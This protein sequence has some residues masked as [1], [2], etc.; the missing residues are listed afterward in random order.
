V[1]FG[2]SAALVCVLLHFSRKSTYLF[3][4]SCCL[5]VVSACFISVNSWQ[6]LDMICIFYLFV[7]VIVHP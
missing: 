4:I 1:Y 7:R 5:F 6:I 3:V 2:S